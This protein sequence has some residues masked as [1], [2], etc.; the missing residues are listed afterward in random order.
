MRSFTANRTRIFAAS[1]FI[2]GAVA[3]AYPT[4]VQA[5]PDAVGLGTAASFGVLAGQGVTNTGPTVVGADLGTCPNPS[6]TGFPPGTVG[7]TIHANDAVACSAQ[8]DLTTAYNDAAGRP[9]DTAYLGPTDLGGKTLVAGVYNGD[10]SFGITGV[11]TLDGQNDPDSVFIF[12]AAS[13]L[14]T[15]TNSS[16][17]FINGA[18]ACNVFWQVGSSATLGVGSTMKGTVMALSAIAAQTGAAI[19]GRL[20]TRNASLTMDTNQVRPAPCGAAIPP[21]TADGTPTTADGTP[22]TAGGTPTTADGTPTT[23]GS[24]EVTTSSTSVASGATTSTSSALGAAG[25]GAGGPGAG[26]PGVG[27]ISLTATTTTRPEVTV[28][29]Q[30]RTPVRAPLLPRTGFAAHAQWIVG[31]LLLACGVVLTAV[32]DQRRLSRAGS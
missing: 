17:A 25:P 18:Q 30:P 29:D 6:V 3:L 12:Q 24:G 28:I 2:A 5:A 20:L 11:L 9:A 14:I 22:T 10:S 1:A 26:G 16:V 7:G 15:A 23:L 27:G 19:D 8:S 13:T 21:S 31:T 32:A 4:S